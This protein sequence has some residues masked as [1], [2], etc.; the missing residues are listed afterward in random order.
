MPVCAKKLS[1][2]RSL[3]AEKRTFEPLPTY[4]VRMKKRSLALLLLSLLLFTVNGFSQHFNYEWHHGNTAAA[5]GGETYNVVVNPDHSILTLLYANNFDVDPSAGTRI[6]SGTSIT[7]C[8]AQ[9]RLVW[10]VSFGGNPV[11]LGLSTDNAGNIYFYGYGSAAFDADP[12]PG[13]VTLT[14]TAT[15]G[16]VIELDP[17]GNYVWSYML[18]CSGSKVTGV[19]FDAANNTYIY[20]A[21]SGTLDADPGAGVHNL[22][23]GGS[24][25]NTLLLK[26]SAAKN[27][28]G[29]VQLHNASA[30]TSQVPSNLAVRNNRIYAA[31]QIYG[32]C[33]FNPNGSSYTLNGSG[34]TASFAACYDTSLLYAHAVTWPVTQVHLATAGTGSLYVSMKANGVFDTDPSAAVHNTTAAG[35]TLVKLDTAFQ[36]QWAFTLKDLSNATQIDVISESQQGTVAIG[37]AF[38]ASSDSVD[39]DPGSGYFPM[40]VP[41]GTSTFFGLYNGSGA[42]LDATQLYASINESTDALSFD[43][44]NN[45]YCSIRLAGIV[46]LDPG[47]GTISYNSNYSVGN[48]LVLEYSLCNTAYATISHSICRGTGYTFGDSTFN[49]SGIHR[50]TYRTAGGCDSIVTLSLSVQHPDTRISCAHDTL[51]CLYPVAGSAYQWIRCSD[52]SAM[53]G[54]TGP[55][56]FPPDNDAYAAVI[57]TAGCTDT[58]QCV[59]RLQEYN[60]G[61]PVLDWAS[62]WRSTAS[63]GADRHLVTD[64][65]GNFYVCGSSTAPI[66][67]DLWGHSDNTVNSSG[68]NGGAYIMKYDNDGNFQWAWH[69][70]NKSMISSD[71]ASVSSIALDNEGNVYATG[72]YHN[73]TDFDPE[74]GNSMMMYGYSSASTASNAARA[75]IL[76]LTPAGQPL[77]VEAVGAA[78]N[79]ME[80]LSIAVAPN[81]NIAIGGDMITG[82]NVDFD[83]GPGVAM[84]G[85]GAFIAEYDNA[86]NY[87]GAVGIQKATTQEADCN[88]VAFDE[89][90]NLWAAGILS[91][92]T[93]FDAGTG[94]TN[95][96]VS[97]SSTSYYYTAKY[98]PAFGL[99]WAHSHGS[100]AT[101]YP[102]ELRPDGDGTMYVMRGSKIY[103][104]KPDGSVSYTYPLSCPTASRKNVGFDVDMYGNV[105]VAATMNGTITLQ[106][107]S[108]LSTGGSYKDLIAKYNK[109]GTNAWA[110]LLTNYPGEKYIGMAADNRGNCFVTAP[111]TNTPTDVDP[112]SGVYNVTPGYYSYYVAKYGSSCSAIDTAVSVTAS[113][114]LHVTA[115]GYYEWKQCG[116]HQLV[117]TGLTAQYT[118]DSTGYYYC[119]IHKGTCVDSTSCRYLVAV[120]AVHISSTALAV[121]AGSTVTFTATT[122]AMG[123]TPAYQ[124]YLNGVAVTGA[125]NATYTAAFSNGDHVYC[126]VTGSAVPVTTLNTG[127]LTVTV[128]TVN[129]AV[130]VT[131]NTLNAMQTGAT[132][133]WLDCSSSYAALPGATAN[134]YTPAASGSYAVMITY[135]GCKD[136]SACYPIHLPEVSITNTALAVCHDAPVSFTAS[137]SYMGGTQS[138]QWYVNNV[139]AAGQTDSVFTSSAFANGDRV[140]CAVSSTSPAALLYTDTLTVTVTT[141]NTTVTSSGATLT[142]AQ[143]GAVYQWLDC[144]AGNTALPGATAQAYTAATDGSY[145]VAISYNGCAD[146][147]ACSTVI[148]TGIA[149][150]ATAGTTA[151]VYP[152]PTQGFVNIDLQSCYAAVTIEISNALG[153][154]VSKKQ[155]ASTDKIELLLEGDKGLYSIRIIADNKEKGIFKVIKN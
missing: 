142:A 32:G 13:T 55:Y 51:K 100:A 146:T 91:A 49:E 85:G 29:Q 149:N 38:S 87:I 83:P 99:L 19:G 52:H 42:F 141:V 39:F 73:D 68:V 16:F 30:S 56:Y 144:Y 65:Y 74:E 63:M 25:D 67:S 72:I 135:D 4:S 15:N 43:G 11:R 44:N 21:F 41:S 94:V 125:T 78:N 116:T 98:S 80:P 107:G 121:C 66:Y 109:D 90:S 102:T 28:M 47:P 139:A 134:G 35:A 115:H 140:Y 106:T 93:D 31:G 17:N 2:S 5:T 122:T 70:G 34:T 127:T 81:G 10:S 130:T 82:I 62:A 117:G 155:Y 110:F 95:I 9:H 154:T 138:Y 120:Q 8:D 132:Y 24:G 22:S 129:N 64:S 133:Q 26:L 137:A 77:W 53:S 124:W 33:D 108:T 71:D 103:R 114:V 88:S 84:I 7:K 145:A 96:S 61:T 123:S 18:N 150:A 152:N 105:Y 113:S 20:G 119:V 50:W 40:V 12:G 37:G 97:G 143:N 147:S 75:F 6:M 136:T 69:C 45:L 23:T 128:T 104:Y 112:S 48:P 60:S 3:P 148:T 131:G 151:M 79:Q 118:P 27:Y 89:Q 58:T 1:N 153:Q 57:T 46:D 111:G 36:Y 14:P 76:K 86:G 126:A 92:T 54:A 101:D 59:Q